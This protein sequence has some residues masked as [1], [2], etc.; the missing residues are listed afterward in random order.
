MLLGYLWISTVQI[1]LF[2]SE[3]TSAERKAAFAT[4]APMIGY[5]NDCSFF[6][7]YIYPLPGSIWLNVPIHVVPL[8]CANPSCPLI[9]SPTSAVNNAKAFVGEVA[10]RGM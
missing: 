9:S 5:W 6:A 4:D 8:N 10:E 7:R 1:G 2:A 3:C